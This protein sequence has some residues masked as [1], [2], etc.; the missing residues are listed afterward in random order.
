LARA[1]T[2]AAAMIEDGA[3]DR[4]VVERYAGWDRGEGAEILAGRRSLGDLAARV[5]RDNVNPH[6]RSGGQEYLENLVN[7]YL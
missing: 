1:L 7:R 2:G 5:E 4:F 3:L 6:P